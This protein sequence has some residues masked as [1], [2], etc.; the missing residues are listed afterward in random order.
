M[1]SLNKFNE[2]LWSNKRSFYS[3]LNLESI[4]NSDRNYG[5][6]VWNTFEMKNIGDYYDLH[7]QSDTLSLTYSFEN[8]RDTCLKTY[9]LDSAK[10]YSAPGLAWIEHWKWQELD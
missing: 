10:F 3:K 8:F 6:K 9:N 5:N 2:T 4:W 1:D 7:V